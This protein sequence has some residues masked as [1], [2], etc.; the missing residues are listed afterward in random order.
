M[1]RRLLVR[2][3]KLVRRRRPPSQHPVLK[4]SSWRGIH[5]NTPFRDLDAA[6]ERA[7]RADVNAANQPP[8]WLDSGPRERW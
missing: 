5:A 8:R 4:G 1:V 3:G 7:R 6:E 2:L